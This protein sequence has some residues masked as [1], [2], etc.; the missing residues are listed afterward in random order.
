MMNEYEYLTEMISRDFKRKTLSCCLIL[1]V[2]YIPSLGPIK[3]NT[4]TETET[5]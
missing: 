5:Q 3:S 4:E 1:N 2:K